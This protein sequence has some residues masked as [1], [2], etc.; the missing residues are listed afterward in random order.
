MAH[1]DIPAYV[2]GLLTDEEAADVRRHLEQGC[3][4]CDAELRS[5]TDVAGA[6]AL[7]VTPV[8][9][10]DGLRRRVLDRIRTRPAESDVH[11]V[12]AGQGKWKHLAPGVSACRLYLNRDRGEIT[13]LLRLEPGAT[14]ATHRHSAP[15]QCYVLEGD[16]SDGVNRFYAGDYECSPAGTV[17]QVQSTENGC[18]LLIISSIHDELIRV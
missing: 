13:S 12:R 14:Y 6:M 7:T 3:E 1:A 17:H 11:V 2:L 10:P 8:A 18:L 5:I 15:E 9:A 4:A 16:V